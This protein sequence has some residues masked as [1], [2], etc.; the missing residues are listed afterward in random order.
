VTD[1]FVQPRSCKLADNKEHREPMQDNAR[2]VDRPLL[3]AA[4]TASPSAD[5]KV[6]II[7][8]CSR[9]SFDR[10]FV[11]KK[12]CTARALFCRKT[13]RVETVIASPARTSIRCDASRPTTPRNGAAIVIFKIILIDAVGREQRSSEWFAARPRGPDIRCARAA[14]TMLPAIER[15]AMARASLSV[16]RSSSQRSKPMLI[17]AL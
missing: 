13:F 5:S 16:Q 12:T 8:I 7:E 4:V 2:G 6:L 3:A 15:D 17:A 11:A 1:G 14:F 10:K 9:S